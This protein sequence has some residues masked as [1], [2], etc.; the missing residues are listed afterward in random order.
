MDDFGKP[1]QPHQPADDKVVI[2][3]V[4]LFCNFF[5]FWGPFNN[6]FVVSFKLRFFF[7]I[8]FALFT[9]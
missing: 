5:K 9:W 1:F 6:A 7:Q 2:T 4:H 8:K 3:F